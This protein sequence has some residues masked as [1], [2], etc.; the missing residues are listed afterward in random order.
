MLFDDLRYEPTLQAQKLGKAD[1][2]TTRLLMQDKQ[3]PVTFW[4]VGH[5]ESQALHV[6]FFKAVMY[7]PATQLHVFWVVSAVKVLLQVLQTPV[8][9]LHLAQFAGQGK[10]LF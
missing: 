4:Q 6:P 5:F 3:S 9:K 7:W 2:L 1:V 8:L 10:Q